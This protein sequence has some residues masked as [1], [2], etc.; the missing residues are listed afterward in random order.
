MHIYTHGHTALNSLHSHMLKELQW[1]LAQIPNMLCRA[2]VGVSVGVTRHV[3]RSIPPARTSDSL[4]GQKWAKDSKL[5]PSL[6]ISA[7]ASATSIICS[8]CDT[9][10]MCLGLFLCNGKVEPDLTGICADDGPERAEDLW[11]RGRAIEI[12]LDYKD[13]GPHYCVT[14]VLHTRQT[15]QKLFMMA[16]ASHYKGDLTFWTWHNACQHVSVGHLISTNKDYWRTLTEKTCHCGDTAPSHL[17]PWASIDGKRLCHNPLY[18]SEAQTH[19]IA[20]LYFTYTLWKSPGWSVYIL[21]IH[22]QIYRQ[23]LEWKSQ[24]PD[25]WLYLSEPKKADC[26]LSHSG[27]ESLSARKQNRT[28][29][30]SLLSTACLTLRFSQAFFLSFWENWV[31]Q[32]L[33]ALHLE[34]GVFC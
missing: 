30:W 7:P 9:A 10:A 23:T 16:L 11:G 6:K 20:F 1:E 32:L 5:T 25:L 26:Y 18:P 27:A 19:P 22:I 2:A 33:S 21:L 34:R 31:T 15:K 13:F 4:R 3:S 8:S 14:K 28:R 29:A 12:L 24:V 17:V